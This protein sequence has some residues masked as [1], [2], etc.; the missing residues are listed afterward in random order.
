[1]WNSSSKKVTAVHLEYLDTNLIWVICSYLF[2]QTLL[3]LLLWNGTAEAEYK[4]GQVSTCSP[5]KETSSLN[6]GNIHSQWE[7]ASHLNI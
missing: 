4:E 2:P 6:S 7:A 5:V 3:H 1:M